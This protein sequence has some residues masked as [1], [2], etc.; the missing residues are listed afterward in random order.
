MSESRPI[1]G[2]DI[3]R[4]AEALGWYLW[5]PSTDEVDLPDG[6]KV[7]AIWA[8]DPKA[9]EWFTIYPSDGDDCGESWNPLLSTDDALALAPAL[10][11][12]QT[13][14]Q[15]QGGGWYVDLQRDSQV[16]VRTVFP[17]PIREAIVQAILIEIPS[18]EGLR[19]AS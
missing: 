6:L 15:M 13:L 3:L 10:G 9:H 12:Q 2:E 5:D 11:Y 7:T 1:T 19:R 18:K 14:V 17:N 16:I 4:I 8:E